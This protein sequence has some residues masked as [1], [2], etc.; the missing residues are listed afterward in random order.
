MLGP[1]DKEMGGDADLTGS[2][3]ITIQN[4]INGNMLIATGDPNIIS[5]VSTVNYKSNQL[6]ITSSVNISGANNYLYLQGTTD[7]G[8]VKTFKVAVS[9]GILRIVEG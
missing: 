1:I 6:N 3:N 7:D 2:D 5:G 9:G 4:N 8:G